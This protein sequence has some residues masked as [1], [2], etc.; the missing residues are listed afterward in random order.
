M[1]FLLLNEK[2]ITMIEHSI[3]EAYKDKYKKNWD[4]LYFAVDLHGTILRKT[5]K[6]VP[7]RKAI[8]VLAKLSSLP[9]IVLI[10]FTST[11]KRE[12]RT[13]YKLIQK[14]NIT[15]EYFNKNPECNSDDIRDFSKKFY[16]NVLFDDRA[17]FDPEKDWEI[18][19]SSIDIVQHM[20]KCPHMLF[21]PYLKK[22]YEMYG[23]TFRCPFS[24]QSLCIYK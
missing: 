6:I 2:G 14:H 19:N 21:C 8:E 5:D 22:E 3:F 9:E 4:K 24:N 11:R 13:F 20:K 10:L 16:Y 15:F 23:K 17:G 7:Y 12:L 18:V 1:N